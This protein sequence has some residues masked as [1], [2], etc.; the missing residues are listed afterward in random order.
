FL[1]TCLFCFLFPYLLHIKQSIFFF[2]TS[3]VILVSLT[4]MTTISRERAIC[5]FYHK[6]Y[7]KTK[8][9]ELLDAIEKKKKKKNSH[10]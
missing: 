9:I 7:D 8:A 4:T 2:K 5:M 6:D 3:Q 10:E 1:Q